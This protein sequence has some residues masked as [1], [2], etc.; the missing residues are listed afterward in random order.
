MSEPAQF[1]SKYVAV[2]AQEWTERND[3]G[4]GAEVFQRQTE[5]LQWVIKERKRT[6]RQTE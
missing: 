3:T 1:P 2:I 6:Q 5:H 4:H